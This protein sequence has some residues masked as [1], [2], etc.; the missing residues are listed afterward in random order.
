MVGSVDPLRGRPGPQPAARGW[1]T[2]RGL[3]TTSAADPV[4]SLRRAR[5][6]ASS[7]R[8]ATHALFDESLPIA[9]HWWADF[10]WTPAM[11]DLGA[12][13]PAGDRLV[14]DH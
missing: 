2:D 9:Q 13:E 4:L 6:A 14:E 3:R 8:I 5:S 11:L 1:G 10:D 12:A 7:F